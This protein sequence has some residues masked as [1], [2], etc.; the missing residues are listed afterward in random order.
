MLLQSTW[1]SIHIISQG[2]EVTNI[3][4]HRRT[5]LRLFSV[6]YEFECRNLII[7]DEAWM[8]GWFNGKRFVIRNQTAEIEFYLSSSHSLPC[9][10]KA[11]NTY[12][13]QLW[14]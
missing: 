3:P 5:C 1:R 4:N 12:S 2:N 13:P 14:V 10:G 11:M 8:Y 9:K 7:V 6:S